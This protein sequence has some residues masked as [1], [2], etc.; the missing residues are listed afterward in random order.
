MSRV[1]QEYN[2]SEQDY[3]KK[4]RT[5]NQADDEISHDNLK[6]LKTPKVTKR[7][8]GKE[9]G[10]P[11]NVLQLDQ[12]VTMNIPKHQKNNRGSAMLQPGEK[13]LIEQRVQNFLEKQEKVKLM[14]ESIQRRKKAARESQYFST[15][16]K[17]CLTCKCLEKN[18]DEDNDKLKQRQKKNSDKYKG[19]DE[20]VYAQMERDYQLTKI[21][22]QKSEEQI[23][24]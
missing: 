18:K 8:N 2:H 3:S 6:S 21:L 16:L 24:I 7:E 5:K 15:K 4:K 13:K 12:S 1:K 10:R 17:R 11:L 19:E 22:N 14:K 20:Q 9:K 23:K